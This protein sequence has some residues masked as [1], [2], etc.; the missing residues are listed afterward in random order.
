VDF[1]L[2]ADVPPEDV[3]ALL[4]ISRRR[5]FAKGEIVFHRD[6]PGDSLHLVVKGSFAVRLMTPLGDTVT[7]AVRGPGDNFGEMALAD[8]A[9]HRSATVAALQPSETMAV[10]YAEF[11]R[12]RTRHPQIDRVLI[13]FL[14]GEIRRQNELLLD[15]LYVPAERRVLRRL[16]ELAEVYADGDGVIALTQEELGE[17]AGTTRAT[18]NRVLR[19]QEERGT[20]AL[21]R[22]QTKIVDRESLLHHGSRGTSRR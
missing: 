8:P 7:V 17:I 6:D 2:L 5:T 20:I 21:K 12:L 22:G 11:E 10:Y 9:S 1:R 14:V 3:R 19:E 13:A 18:V 16:A 4:A 15:A